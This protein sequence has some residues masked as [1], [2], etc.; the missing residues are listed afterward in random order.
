LSLQVE[1]RADDFP[2]ETVERLEV[3]SKH[4]TLLDLV[5][6]KDRILLQ[7]LKERE[8]LLL[9]AQHVRTGEHTQRG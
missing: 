4:T 7:L 9:A 5:A 3:C 8:E 1:V 6:A 2:R